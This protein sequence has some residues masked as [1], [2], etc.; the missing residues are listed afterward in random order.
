LRKLQHGK[1][2]IEMTCKF[3]SSAIH[4][5]TL[6]LTMPSCSLIKVSQARRGIGICL[7]IRDRKTF[8]L[9]KHFYNQFQSGG[10]SSV[11]GKKFCALHYTNKQQ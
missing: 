1:K 6:Q 4:S 10:K 5:D 9:E 11:P 7:K 2:L 8:Y 3:R